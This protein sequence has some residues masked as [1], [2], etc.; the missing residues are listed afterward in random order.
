MPFFFIYIL[1]LSVS[2]AVVFLFYHFVLRKLTFYNWNR[3]Y[4]LGYT[5]LAFFISFI[6]I[7]PV[8]EKN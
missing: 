4:L 3:W 7:S 1:K 2:L 8:L 6:N 5:I